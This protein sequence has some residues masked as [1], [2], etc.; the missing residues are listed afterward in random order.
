[1]VNHLEFLKQEVQDLKDQNLYGA[2]PVFSSQ[3][4]NKV[5]MNGQEVITLSTNNYLG[6]ANHP[7]LAAAAKA[8]MDK[9]G[10]GTGAVRQIAG[11]MEIHMEFEE[12]LA[13][14]KNTEE[15]LMFVAGIA[16]NRGTIQCLMGKEDAII[17]D[18]LNHGSIIDGVRLTKSAR[19]IYPHGDMDGLRK[20][21]VESKAQR[22]RLVVTDGVFSMD[23]DIAPLD[24]IAELC[25]EFDAILMVDDAH[26]DG[27]L[28]R[29]GRG[30]VDHFNLHG[31]VDI[32]MGTMSKAFGCMGGYIAGPAELKDWLTNRARSFLFTTAHPPALVGAC[33]EAIKMV[34]D[35]PQHLKNLWDNAKYL[36]KGLNDLGFDTGRSETPITPVIV[37]EPENAS[38]LSKEML[39]EGVFVK[40]IV[41]PLVAKDKSRVRTIVT[42]QHTR[43]DLDFC[44]QKF[45]EV[46]KRLKLL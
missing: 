9:W 18:E 7:R 39:K 37:G 34:Q 32:D 11:T 27:V 45:E 4:K 19:Y 44:L 2:L 29:D 38:M 8:A 17:S 31:K 26:G 46:G 16:A 33:M 25:E 14:Y 41:Y 40:P 28:G 1:M 36:K 3:Q 43:E 13:E 5:I 42:A 21:L 12:Q 10:F 23:G 24:K 15:S 22:R 6:F 35:E 30:I 20:V